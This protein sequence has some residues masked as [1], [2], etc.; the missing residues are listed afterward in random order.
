MFTF[1]ILPILF[2]AVAILASMPCS[3]QLAIGSDADSLV[4]KSGESFSYEGLT[5]TPSADFVLTNTT[6]SRTDAKTL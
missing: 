3:A 5:L 4:I 6:L 1:R 2:S